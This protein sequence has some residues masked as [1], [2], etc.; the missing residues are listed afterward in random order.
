MIFENE[1]L[2]KM[3]ITKNLL[4]EV[5][6]IKYTIN[7]ILGTILNVIGENLMQVI[8]DLL[9]IKVSIK[10]KGEVQHLT[11]QIFMNIVGNFQI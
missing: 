11:N 6:W 2:K 3:A 4:E 10:I 5:D 7:K 9:F 8:P 1:A